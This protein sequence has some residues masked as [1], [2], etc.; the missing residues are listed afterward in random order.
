MRVKKRIHIAPVGFEVDRIV[1]PAITYEADMV[2]LLIHNNKADDKAGPYVERIIEQLKKEK[3]EIKKVFADWRDVESITKEARKLFL[4]L[5]GNDIYVNIASGS[6][7]HAIALDRAIM[8][9]ADQ[10]NIREFYA[11]SEAYEGFK[12][13][14]EQ[15]SKG[16]REVKEIPKRKMVLPN[17]RLLG[18][19]T[20]IRDYNVNE[21]GCA[22]SCKKDH[23]HIKKRIKKKQL[24]ESC[25]EQGILPAA[26]NKLTSLDKNIIQKL[27]DKWDFIKIEKIGQSFY[28]GLTP[29]GEA[30]VHEMTS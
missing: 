27:A 28:V 30:H 6:K 5:A 4:S 22:R 1:Q 8:T 23:E 9:L 11:E 21:G 19:L 24:A 18:A 10:S 12:P 7:N 15:L 17:E 14:K 16:V 25:I 2:Y 20:I 26:G 13:G 3:I 29:Q